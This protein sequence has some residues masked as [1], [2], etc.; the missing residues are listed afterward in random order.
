MNIW[1]II[2]VIIFFILWV[3]ALIVQWGLIIWFILINQ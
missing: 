1:Y 3:A 2:G